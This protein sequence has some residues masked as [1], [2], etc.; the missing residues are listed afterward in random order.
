M[1]TRRKFIKIAGATLA[2]AVVPGCTS[3]HAESPPP[4]FGGLTPNADFYVY[5]WTHVPQINAQ[6]WRLKIQGL[7][8]QPLSLS[9]YDIKRLPPVE[10]TLT[11]DCISNPPD[12]KAIS[13][14]RWTGAKLTQTLQVDC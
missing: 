5:S 11:L 8:N 4:S 9:Y 3:P 6:N 13:N 10:Q 14:A 12:G 2:V 1:L 7:V